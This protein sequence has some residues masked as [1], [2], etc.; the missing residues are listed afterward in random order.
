MVSVSRRF[1]KSIVFRIVSRVSPGN[2]MM[3]SPWIVK[4]SFLQFSV[5]LRAISMMAPFLDVFQDLRVSG[6]ITGNEQTA[7]RFPHRLERF[8]IRCHPR[9][10]R[11]SKPERLE[12]RT[13]LKG[14]GLPVIEGVVIEKDFLDLRKG[15]EPIA[16]LRCNVVA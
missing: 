5:N 11:P 2:P 1:A 9:G 7:T 12:L 13:Q 4:P 3:K 10:A 14:T 6:F 15:T 16:N 8:V